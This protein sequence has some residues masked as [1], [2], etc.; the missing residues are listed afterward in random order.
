MEFSCRKREVRLEISAELWEDEYRLKNGVSE[1]N[2]LEVVIV[3]DEERICQ[4]I[5][6]LIDWEALGMHVAGKAHNGLDA[7]RLVETIRPHILIT[8]IRM[9]GCSGLELI[10]QVKKLLPELEIIVISGYAHFEYAQQAIQ[11]GVGYYLLK[12]VSRAELTSMLEKLKERISQRLESEQDKEELLRRAKNDDSRMKKNLV[13]DLADG[14]Y[15]ELTEENLKNIYHIHIRRGMYQ[16]FCLKADCNHAA[17]HESSREILMEKLQEILECTLREKDAELVFA[18]RGFYCM[19]I[20][21]YEAGKQEE[22][23]RA[24]KNYLSHAQLQR[25]L[26]AEADFSLAVGGAYKEVQKLSDSMEEAMLL[27]KERY[28]KGSGRFLERMGEASS[29]HEYNFLEKYLRDITHA[30]EVISEPQADAAVEYLQKETAIIPHVRG[31]EILELVHAAAD[32]FAACAQIPERTRQ[33]ELFRAQCD[34]CS[35][36]EKLFACLGDFQRKFIREMAE[37]REN[38]AI[39]PVRRAKEYIQAHYG[40]PL[41]QEEISD[42]VGLSTAYFSALFKK[43]EGEGFAKYLIHVRIEQAKI[44]LRESNFPVMEICRKV[45]YNDLKHFTHT[46]EKVTGVKP[47]VYRKLYG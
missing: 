19:G 34:D 30:V 16:A 24:L 15:P 17:F 21:N 18:V 11:Y 47:S 42:M 38:D 45:G 39:R 4:L 9:P 36:A 46:F 5:T 23:R 14:S 2:R 40:E 8:D 26:F 7:C 6:A 27:I 1:M 29:L 31:Y 37:K 28:V 41:T 33:L 25:S 13:F 3:D 22:I 43:T 35:H 20:V 44:L 12:P 10:R 32:I